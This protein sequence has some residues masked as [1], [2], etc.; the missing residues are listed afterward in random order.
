MITVLLCLAFLFVSQVTFADPAA[1]YFDP[2]MMHEMY[3][4]NRL[5]TEQEDWKFSL[6]LSPFYQHA[7][8]ARDDRGKKVPIGDRL[9]KWAML[10]ILWG[11]M[12]AAPKAFTITNY[13]TLYTL[14]YNSTNV[15][16]GYS[17]SESGFEG[18]LDTDGDWSVPIEYEKK[19]LR[20]ELD[21]SMMSGFGFTIKGGIVDYRQTPTFINASTI[22]A[23]DN[24]YV[25]RFLT[26]TLMTQTTREALLVTDLGY[27]L[28]PYETTAFEDT[29]FQ[30]Y[31]SNRFELEDKKGVHV[32]TVSP[33]FGLGVW[34]P[35][36]KK[37]DEDKAFSLPSGHDGFWGI[38]LEGAINFEFPKTVLFNFGGSVTLF[39]SKTQCLR[40]P[41]HKYQ[42]SFYPF[43]AKVRRTLGPSWNINCTM[44]ANDILDGLSVYLEYL[45]SKHERDTIT[46]KDCDDV[47][48]NSFLPQKL[49]Q[50]SIWRSQMVQLGFEYEMS[51]NLSF[52]ACGQTHISGARVYKTHTIMGTMK[53]SF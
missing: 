27:N 47:R 18:D 13:A 1:L 46:I 19:G 52:G 48:R 7:T 8:G 39:E 12:N 15:G 5:P 9:G 30:F 44:H 50:E 32:A 6:H 45:Y 14:S 53:F 41:N 17:M 20:F 25:H 3:G 38:T 24:V 36:G 28:D 35:T 34:V 2:G 11:D 26:E 49:E 31:W 43:K 42:S 10:P 29:F 16:G 33:Y 4:V 22:T 37:K 23:A 40:V 21:A 51:P